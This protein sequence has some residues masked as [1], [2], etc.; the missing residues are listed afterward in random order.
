MGRTMTIVR[1]KRHTFFLTVEEHFPMNTKEAI[2]HVHAWLE[3]CGG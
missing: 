3:S 2:N 1:P